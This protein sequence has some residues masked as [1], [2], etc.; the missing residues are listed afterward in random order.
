[1]D[2]RKAAFYLLIVLAGLVCTLKFF[3]ASREAYTPDNLIR[4]HVIA[5]SNNPQDQEIKYRVRDALMSHLEEKLK[6]ASTYEEAYRAVNNEK[7]E[8]LRI[9]T[10][11]VAGT[12]SSYPVRVDIGEYAFPTRAYGKLILP[13]GNYHAVK[14]VLGNGEGT[15]WW[16]VLFPPLC[17]VDVSG[18]ATD[19][20]ETRE[21]L[22][23]VRIRFIDWLQDSENQLARLFSS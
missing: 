8:L 17:L 22:S 2:K 10:A 1:M 12:G 14:V 16:C 13:A 18:E 11:V 4:F 19:T 20:S 21:A 9:A 15:N 5:N 6:T 23:L 7:E 3:V